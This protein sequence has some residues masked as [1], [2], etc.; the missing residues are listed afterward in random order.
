[1]TTTTTSVHKP[2][3][4]IRYCNGCRW[5]LRSAWYAQELLSTFPE[6]LG[7]VALAPGTSGMFRIEVDGQLLWCRERDGGF[8][9][10]KELKQRVRDIIAPLRS[11]G[12]SDKPV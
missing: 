9:E 1:M 3:I 4:T 8:P 10:I 11:L 7:E 6:E 2:K 5:L 12:H